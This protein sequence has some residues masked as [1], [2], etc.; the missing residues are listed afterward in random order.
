[1]CSL[2]KSIQRSKVIHSLNSYCI[3]INTTSS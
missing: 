3:K 1:M 2:L